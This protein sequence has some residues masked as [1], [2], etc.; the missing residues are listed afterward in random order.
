MNR[1]VTLL[2]GMLISAPSL[3]SAVISS[4][5][6]GI[7][8]D[9]TTWDCSCIPGSKDDVIINNTHNINLKKTT[10]IFNLTIQTGGSLNDNGNGMTVSGN[11]LVDGTYKGVQDLTLDGKGTT[12]DGTGSIIIIKRN[13][14]LT[15]FN[16]TILNTANLTVVAGSIVIDNKVIITNNGSIDLTGNLDGRGALAGWVNDANAN[17]TLDGML[18][19]KQGILT[20]TASGNTIAYKGADQIIK[21]PLGNQYF[22]L[23]LSGGGTSFLP[24]F[25]DL[26]GDL[27]LSGSHQ[28]DITKFNYNLFIA[29]NWSNTS[30]HADPF[31]ER[32]GTVTFDGSGTQTIT[33]GETFFNIII[34]PASTTTVAATT[35]KL[36]I[37]NNW[38]NTGTF[39]PKESTVQFTGAL[40]QSITGATDW[41][42]L[43]INVNTTVVSGNQTLLGS[44]SPDGGVFDISGVDFTLLSNAVRT[45][46]VANGSGSVT[47]DFIIQRYINECPGWVAVAAPATGL[48]LADWEDDIYMQGFTGVN[49]PTTGDPNVYS[50]DESLPGDAED[51]GW[52]PASNVTDP[53]VTGL[54]TYIYIWDNTQLPTTLSVKGPVNSGTIVFPVSYTDSGSPV[55]DGWNLVANPY[56]STIDWDVATGSGWTKDGVYDLIMNWDRCADNFGGWAAGVPFGAGGSP[57]IPSGQSFFVQTFQSSPL[58]L[59]CDERVKVD[60]EVKLRDTR[61]ISEV[62][63]IKC[64]SDQGYSDDIGIRF[65]HDATTGLDRKYDAQ[66][67][68]SLS[69]NTPSIYTVTQNSLFAVNA[70]PALTEDISV[71]LFLKVNMAGSYTLEASE[72][73]AFPQ[74]AT[75]RLEDKKTGQFTDF[76]DMGT[77][78][79]MH[80]PAVDSADRFMVHFTSPFLVEY[81]P[82]SCHG[83]TDG[84]I[85]LAKETTGHWDIYWVSAQGDTLL[86]QNQVTGSIQQDM[87]NLPAGQ[88]TIHM[89]QGAETVLQE[90]VT[91]SEPEMIQTGA[92]VIPSDCSFREN[93]AIDLMVSG[94]TPPY[95]FQWSTGAETED[96]AHLSDGSYSVS[97]LDQHDCALAESF[98]LRSEVEMNTSFIAESDTV[99]LAHG[100]QFLNHSDGALAYNWDFG[101]GSPVN[102]TFEPHH[103]YEEAGN[104]QVNL[105]A[106]NGNCIDQQSMSVTVIDTK[107]GLDEHTDQPFRPVLIINHQ[108]LVTVNFNL[109]DPEDVMVSVFNVTGQQ[110]RSPLT[111]PAV[112][113]EQITIDL[114]DLISGVYLVRVE[115]DNHVVSQKVTVNH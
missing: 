52:V 112:I 92:A 104:Y 97:V 58:D 13:V 106:I 115:T 100:V 60:Q 30:N 69:D 91:I 89:H 61:S 96:I 87:I 81:H 101:D 23:T 39:D 74:S 77:Y 48:T 111:V 109:E 105:T 114:D 80:D 103:I 66:K 22:H 73:G 47:G 83:A 99:E 94:G 17:L 86:I 6:S 79:F 84:S 44:L 5:R 93:G 88:Y 16:K 59:S 46:R 24:N 42:N 9:K 32:K 78:T 68:F 26:G 56:P 3:Y 113:Q 85:S 34:G 63:K 72:F 64:T 29:G 67:L 21:L 15:K 38:V 28:L 51:N 36:S 82:I 1:I 43:I 10:G 53:L 19:A 71:P 35:D 31:V 25:L 33:G 11:L 75:I 107:T 65:V 57:Y 108:N 7:W 90:S 102:N 50:Y 54:G 110:V 37:S 12:I 8:D 18:L 45:G 49:Y 4:V 76:R 41:Y 62:L 2:L 40:S 20:A 27:T 55:E 70:L 98:V 95:R 14:N